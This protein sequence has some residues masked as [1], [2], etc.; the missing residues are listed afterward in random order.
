MFL[1]LSQQNPRFDTETSVTDGC[2]MDTLEYITLIVEY[3]MVIQWRRVDFIIDFY[4]RD[5]IIKSI[6]IV[7][8]SII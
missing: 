1:L 6:V 2:L 4:N 5:S 8:D 7:T 3:Y